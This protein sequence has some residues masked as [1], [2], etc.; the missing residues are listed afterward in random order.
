MTARH[1]YY[2]IGQRILSIYQ[3]SSRVTSFK[4]GY[5]SFSG[6]ILCT[7]LD[8]WKLNVHHKMDTFHF[9]ANG[10]NLDPWKFRFASEP[11]KTS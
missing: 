3:Y 10:E 4:N 11:R 9:K 5:H 8:K 1:V 7:L 6:A 2:V